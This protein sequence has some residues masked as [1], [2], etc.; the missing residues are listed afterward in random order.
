M[1]APRKKYR[2]LAAGHRGKR[3]PG[4]AQELVLTLSVPDGEVIKVETLDKSGKRKQ[5]TEEEFAELAGD[6]DVSPEEIFAAAIPDAS[7]EDEFELDEEGA[8]EEEA[9]ERF[10]LRE[11]IADQLLRRGIRRLILNRLSRREKI[12]RQKPSTRK[13]AQQAEDKTHMNG[14]GRTV[15]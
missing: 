11:M 14:Q 5:L 12:R 7:G 1:S 15:N 6:D 2:T 3:A 9:L 13:A 4:R 8:S 10:I